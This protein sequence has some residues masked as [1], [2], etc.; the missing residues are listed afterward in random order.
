MIRWLIRLLLNGGALL[1]VSYWFPEV[2]VESYAVAVLAAFILGLVNTV[3][4]PVLMF[5]TIPLRMMTLGLFWFVVNAVTFALTAYLIDGFEIGEWP[6]SLVTTIL[7]AATMS[8]LGWIID[9]VFR[10]SDD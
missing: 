10:K 8:F 7:A 5:L 4:R 9:L 6:M 2:K 3:I 1:L